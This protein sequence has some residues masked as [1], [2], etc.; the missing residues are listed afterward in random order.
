MKSLFAGILLLLLVTLGCGGY[1]SG[2]GNTP[3]AMPQIAPASGTFSTPLTVTISDSTPGAVIYVTTDG[4]MPT[5][6]SHIYQGPF[7]L[8]QAGTAKV[9]AIAA[10]GGY[11]TSP[12]A[13]ANLTLQ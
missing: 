1:G 11:S 7:A 6:S 8:T 4:T 5:L 3:A 2:M 13:V 9:Q 10:A 12:V